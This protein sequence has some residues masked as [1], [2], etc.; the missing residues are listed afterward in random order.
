MMKSYILYKNKLRFTLLILVQTIRT[1]TAVGV[2]ILLNMLIDAVSAAILSKN[3]HQ[4]VWC[5][6]ICCAYAFV[7]GGIVLISEKLKSLNIKHILLN[8]RNDIAHGI[9]NKSIPDFQTKNSAEYIT[10][11][12]QNIS[13]FEENYLKNM[14]S[15]YDSCLSIIIAVILLL[16]INPVIAVISIAAMTIPSL[17]PKFFGKRLGMLQEKIMQCSTN[18]NGKI[19][20]MLNGFEVIKTYH[21]EVKTQNFHA[22]SANVLETSKAQMGNAMAWLYGLS[23]MASIAVQFLIMLLAGWFAVKGVITIGSII[24]VTQL[25]GQV[26]SPAFELSEKIS[27]LKSVKPICNQIKEV[28]MPIKNENAVLDFQEMQRALTLNDISFSYKDAPILNHVNL[29]FEYGKKYAVVG[30]SGSGKS[31]LLKLLAGYYN[32]YSG[33]ILLDG[34]D[35]AK[36]DLVLI[37]Q[38]VF[39]FD[40]TIRNNITLYDDYPEAAIQEAVNLAGLDEVIKGLPEGLDSRVEENGSR[41]SGGERQRIAVARAILHRKNVFLIDEATSSL[42]NETAKKVEESMLSLKNATCISVTHRLIPELL[43]KYDEILVM[44]NGNIV[45]H[46]NYARLIDEA[47]A[48]AKLCLVKV[49]D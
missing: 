30:K 31:T 16:W 37:H 20:D 39:L 28:A 47:G 17:I 4:L 49:V 9:F 19:K 34:K 41:F 40:D 14:L 33:N 6:I 1:I 46:G 15:I 10:L 25:T 35:N 27:K 29:Q 21:M 32:N 43:Q 5:A 2:A 26:I 11:L 8:V 7:F 12:N 42:D 23:S 3:I 13:T 36:C 18:Y 45:E 24:A 38:N 44:D 22:D 48:F